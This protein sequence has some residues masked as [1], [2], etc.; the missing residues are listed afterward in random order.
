[1]EAGLALKVV[2]TGALDIVTV[3]VVDAVELPAPLEAVS[4]YTVVEAGDTLFVPVNDTVPTSGPME[5]DVASA[6][7]HD[8][9]AD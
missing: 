2:I 5:T 8:N 4:L 1:M 9:V 7:F 6:T 3:T